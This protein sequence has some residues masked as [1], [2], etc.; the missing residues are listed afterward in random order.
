MHC[1]KILQWHDM[2][3]VEAPPVNCCVTMNDHQ[4]RH[5][6]EE[7]SPPPYS[8]ALFPL[9]MLTTLQRLQD[10]R[11]NLRFPSCSSTA[12]R[13]Y[14]DLLEIV[15]FPV[16]ALKFQKVG[17]GLLSFKCYTIKYSLYAEAIQNV[18]RLSMSWLAWGTH[19]SSTYAKEIGLEWQLW[20][21][22]TYIF[23]VRAEILKKGSETYNWFQLPRILHDPNFL[24]FSTNMK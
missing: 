11:I 6:F 9:P 18:W 14:Y 13:H 8:L 20:L 16:R 23:P 22:S 5:N 15:V 7:S 12:H 19:T 2:Y 10:P 24:L 21:I 4:R 3:P 17:V 1:S